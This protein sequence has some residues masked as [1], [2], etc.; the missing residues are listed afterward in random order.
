MPRARNYVVTHHKT[1]IMV[2]QLS[3]FWY[4]AY[5][6]E[7]HSYSAASRKLSHSCLLSSS[8]FFIFYLF[9]YFFSK[10]CDDMFSI[11]P[12]MS[13]WECYKNSPHD[14]CSFNLNWINQLSESNFLITQQQTLKNS[15]RSV[16]PMF[17]DPS[18]PSWGWSWLERWMAARPWESRGTMDKDLPNDHSS[19]K[20]QSNTGGEINKSYARYLLNSEKDSPTASQKTTQSTFQSPQTP[21]K[22]V[23]STL[24][25]KVK[26]ASPRGRWIVDDDTKSMVS[27]QSDKFRRHSITG[28]SIRDDESL[29]SSPALPSYMVP[30]ESARAKSRLQSPFG[31]KNG[32]LEKGSSESAK[33]RL[34]FPASPARPRRHS[35]PPKVDMSSVSEN[36]ESN[37]MVT[38]IVG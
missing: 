12:I 22:P 6:L 26:S 16:N 9:M 28:S 38:G 10:L 13:L 34:S 19:V 2:P 17:M 1:S 29:V 31:E 23:S 36:N 30:T 37:G 32:V 33:K 3:K 27:V 21:S 4:M 8:P 20:S 5:Q 18:N 7:L 15:S 24:P 35:G 25:K 11:M 14:L